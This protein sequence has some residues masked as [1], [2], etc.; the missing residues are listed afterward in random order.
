[1]FVRIVIYS[2]LVAIAITGWTA[3]CDRHHSEYGIGWIYVGMPAVF[4]LYVYPIILV[5]IQIFPKVT[6]RDKRFAIIAEIPAMYAHFVAA[7]P[8]F[9]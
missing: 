2:H 4:S 5:G 6:Q 1:M 8:L 9:Q 7:L 3:Y